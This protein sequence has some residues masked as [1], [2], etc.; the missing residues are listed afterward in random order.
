MITHIITFIGDGS[1]ARTH[2]IRREAS[3]VNPGPAGPSLPAAAPMPMWSDGIERARVAE[4][5]PSLLPRSSAPSL[6]PAS[7]PSLPPLA[8]SPAPHPGCGLLS[9]TTTAAVAVRTETD[10]S[11]ASGCANTAPSVRA[12]GGEGS[13]FPRAGQ[14]H[15]T[16]RYLS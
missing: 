2:S 3:L 10:T 9:P 1:A 5:P 14:P 16:R 13:V 8:P 7:P 15:R 6:P 12:G 11:F 4:Q